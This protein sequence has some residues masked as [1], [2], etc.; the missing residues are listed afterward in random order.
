MSRSARLRLEPGRS[1]GVPGD[2][3]D[4]YVFYVFP[5]S[6]WTLGIRPGERG[7]GGLLRAV[8]VRSSGQWRARHRL[9]PVQA[10]RQ[11]TD[12]S[13]EIPNYRSR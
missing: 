1:Y 8:L 5:N 2:P 10:Q 4:P 12:K 6:V 13:N 7:V 3:H 11:V 9:G